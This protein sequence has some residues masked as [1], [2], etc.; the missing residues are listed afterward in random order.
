MRINISLCIVIVGAFVCG[1]CFERDYLLAF[2]IN[3]GAVFVNLPLAIRAA[4]GE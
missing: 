1:I 3:A 2:V 4:K